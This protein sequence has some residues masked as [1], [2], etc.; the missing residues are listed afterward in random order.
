MGVRLSEEE[1]WAVLDA[2]H[3]GILTSLRADGSPVSLPVWFVAA[4]RRLYVSGPSGTAKFTRIRRDP[5][6]AFLVE[7]GTR[8]AELV[9]VHVSGRAAVVGDDGLLARVGRAMEA[10]YGQFRSSPADLPAATR[11]HYAQPVTT[12]EI[13]PE[14]PF[15]SWDNARLGV[16]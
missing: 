12:I 3:T 16:P 5:R 13:V 10:K 11:A 6:V 9:A 15:L 8:W 7:S 4:D 2:S 14:G 1:A